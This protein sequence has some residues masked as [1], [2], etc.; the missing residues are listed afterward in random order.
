MHI[1]LNSRGPGFKHATHREQ[2]CVASQQAQPLGGNKRTVDKPSLF[3]LLHLVVVA[4]VENAG[5][6][7]HM[8]VVGGNFEFGSMLNFSGRIMGLSVVPLKSYWTK[9]VYE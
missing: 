2:T 4:L 6:V 1:E 5:E 3:C 8:V 9:C 7:W